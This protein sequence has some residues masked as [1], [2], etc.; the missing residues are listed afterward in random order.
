MTSLLGFSPE[1]LVWLLVL[2]AVVG[3]LALAWKGPEL[4]S[5]TSPQDR[6]VRELAKMARQAKRHN[7]IV[8]Y[9]D[10]LPFVITHQRRGLVYMLQGRV[11]SRSELIRALGRSGLQTVVRVESEERMSLPNPTRMTL[12]DSHLPR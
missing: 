5:F 6:A 7:T 3:L 12:L 10:G 9:Q 1:M 8:R 2:G 4:W 11:V